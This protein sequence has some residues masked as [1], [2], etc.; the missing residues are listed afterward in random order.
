MTHPTRMAPI[1]YKEEGKE[2][3]EKLWQETM[4]ELAFADP[5]MLLKAALI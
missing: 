2:I 3:G 1:L 4:E 5:E